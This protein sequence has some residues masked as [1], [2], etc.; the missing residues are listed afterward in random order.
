M[1]NLSSTDLFIFYNI[2]DYENV[3]RLI[4]DLI[5]TFPP[6]VQFT[7]KTAL[8]EAIDNSIE[9]GDFPIEVT[10]YQTNLELKICVR[11][12][13]KGFA[14]QPLI[15]LILRDGIDN[16]FDGIKFGLRGRG[17]LLMYKLVKSVTFNTKGNEVNLRLSHPHLQK[18]LLQEKI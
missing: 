4:D 3:M 7:A 11:D 15:E 1:R 18:Q 17:I 16:L 2:E 9:H 12:S 14:V 5:Y 6:K 13:G 8:M 10:F